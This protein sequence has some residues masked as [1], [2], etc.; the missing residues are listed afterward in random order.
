MTTEQKIVQSKVDLL[1]PARPGD[2]SQPGKVPIHARDSFCR[3]R[4]LSEAGDKSAA[5]P[6]KSPN[7]IDANHSHRRRR[8]IIL[9]SSSGIIARFV[10]VVTGLLAVPITLHYL[11]NDRFGLWMS[12]TSFVYFLTFAD[13]GLGIGL[14]N[15][16]NQCDG[17]DN[18]TRPCA[19]ISSA[20]MVVALIGVTLSAIAAY[21]LPIMPL[22]KLIKTETD[23]AAQELL[24][25]AQAVTI[26]FAIGLTSGLIQRIFSAY[27]RGYWSN[28]SL[29]LGRLLALASLLICIWMRASLPLIAFLFM[30]VPYVVTLACSLP[31]FRANPWLR[32]RVSHI[33]L[34]ELHCVS[35]IGV[36]GFGAQIAASLMIS[37]PAIIIAN[38]L[39]TTSVTPYS[40]TQ[41]L[42]GVAGI[43]FT[44][45]L[46]PLWPAYGEAAA[47]GDMKWVRRTFGR[48]VVFGTAIM[49]PLTLLVLVFGQRLILLWTS[50]PEAIPGFSLLLACS[51][52]AMI[53]AWNQVC[54][55]LLNGLNRMGGQAAYGVVLS[56]IALVAAWFAGGGTDASTVMWCMVGFGAVWA[57]LL[58]ADAKLGIQRGIRNA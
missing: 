38:R 41:R 2:F 54:A 1:G 3:I 51:V 18:R 49:V 11:G 42:L 48:S 33:K 35:R 24:P 23:L 30:F 34:S 47:R 53:M 20:I 37:G 6:H 31:F 45:A 25:T 50:Q 19:L 4:E 28:L 8:A 36:L 58:A 46:Q 22:T 52:W 32:P 57:I 10:N 27:Q 21:I 43:I 39:G 5:S 44:V 26:A 12:I 7:S 17:Q 29:A 13:M 15:A 9:T 40:I 14:Q 55:M 16:L 56:L